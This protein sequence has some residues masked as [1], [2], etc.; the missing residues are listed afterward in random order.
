MSKLPT[1]AS[2]A[3]AV[4]GAKLSAPSALRN[5]PVI[6]D[7]ILTH[8]PA[9]GRALEIASGTGQH[10]TALAERFPNIDWFPTEISPERIASIDA[11]A[12]EAALPN[13]R[14]AQM[15]DAAQVGWSAQHA[16][17]NLVYLGNLLHLIPQSAAQT[18]LTEAAQTLAPSGTAIFYGPFMRNGLLTSE[19]DA[20]F[21][22]QLREAD[23]A[24]G[25]KDDQWVQ[26]I[27]T[28]S[29]LTVTVEPMPANNIAFIARRDQ[30]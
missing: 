29:G 10:I 9:Q 26:D 7:L 1:S 8:A 24:I 27:L 14:P 2:V 15:L 6:L 5:L 19:G 23:S 28:R 30:I 13:L 17:C 11:Y 20:R 3:T 16:A 12:A 4:E 21:D 25:Y 22:A 18:I